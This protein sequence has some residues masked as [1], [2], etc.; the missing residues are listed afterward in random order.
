MHFASHILDHFNFVPREKASTISNM[1]VISNVKVAS[2]ILMKR[3]EVRT[4][5]LLHVLRI[6]FKGDSDLEWARFMS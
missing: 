1:C 2:K 5:P 3:F 6:F 4:I